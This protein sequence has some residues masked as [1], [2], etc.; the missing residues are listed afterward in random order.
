MFWRLVRP[1]LMISVV[2]APSTVTV[3]LSFPTVFHCLL[4]LGPLVPQYRFQPVTRLL[5][6]RIYLR[7]RLLADIVQLL[8][9]VREYLLYLI[10]LVV[11]KVQAINHRVQMM[12]SKARTGPK[13]RTTVMRR[14]RMVAAVKIQCQ[15]AGQKAKGEY[16]QYSS[17]NLPFVFAANFHLLVIALKII[18][19]IVQVE[20]RVRDL[21]IGDA[22]V[23][24]RPRVAHNHLF[25]RIRAG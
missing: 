9:G 5:A 23:E 10:L 16:E 8:S 4:E 14:H 19:L 7:A 18:A 20:Y 17:P 22:I 13:A 6:D 12:R 3:P 21:R 25:S 1:E 2:V 11:G 24:G 15:R